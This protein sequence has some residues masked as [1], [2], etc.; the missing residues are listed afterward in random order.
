MLDRNATHAGVHPTASGALTRLA[1]TQAKASGLDAEATL[2]RAHLTLRQIEDSS[3][4]LKVQN[5]ISFV[6]LVARDLSDEFLGFHL[7]LKPDLREIGWLYY[8]SASSSNFSEALKRAA[9]YSSF[10]NEGISLQQA[11]NG[12]L[13]V[14]INYVGVSRHLD[15]HQ[16]EFIVTILLRMA[17]QVTDLR[18]T[19]IR[20]R[21]IHRRDHICPE[22]VDFFG[23]KIEFGAPVD[24]I[25]FASSVRDAPIASADPFLNK[26]LIAYCEEALARRPAHRPSFISSVENAIIPLLPHG[27]AL[28][29]EIAQRLGVSQRTLARSLSAEGSTFSEVLESLRRDLADRYLADRD[30]SISEVAWLL[31]YQEVSAFT[32]AFRRWT[33]RSPR[34][35]RARELSDY[36]SSG[37]I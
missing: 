19:P 1:Y 25:T 4:R 12:G 15:R 28:S 17:R 14:R 20:M 13:T 31:G 35:V 36:E 7:A 34:Y 30:L 2:T 37:P 27:K 11:D 24:D 8:V 22:F 32:H 10:V 33:G 26:L 18:L 5:Q 29:G 3:A 16:I 6:N 23:G 21:F 9:R